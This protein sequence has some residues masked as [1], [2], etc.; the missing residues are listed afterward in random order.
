[1]GAANYFLPMLFFYAASSWAV[2]NHSPG[3]KELGCKGKYVV[4]TILALFAISSIADFDNNLV[5]VIFGSL[6]LG[7]LGLAF[8]TP[9]C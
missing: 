8:S 9:D 4:C 3:I 2:C 1:M 5:G 6:I 7:A